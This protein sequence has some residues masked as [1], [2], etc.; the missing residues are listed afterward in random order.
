MSTIMSDIELLSPAGSVET[1]YA[2]INAGAD[3]VY[4]GGQ[5]FGARA[6]AENPD[7]SQ[8]L[9]AIDY[10][11]LN[12]KKI[13]LTVNTLLKDKEIEEQLYNYILPLYKQG[14]DAVI[15]QDIGVFCYIKNNFPD[16]D[17]HISTQMGVSGVSAAKLLK[18][19]G[20]SRIVTARELSLKELKKIHDNV[21]IEIESFI[22]GAMCYSYSGMCLFSSVAGGRSGNRGRC[23]GPC[24]QPYELYENGRHINNKNS[25]YALS[26]KDMNTLSILPEIINSGVYSLK[27]EGR[28]K[29]PEYVAGVVSVYRKYIDLYFDK[30]LENY[31]ISEED[32]DNLLGMYSRS[33]SCTG[34]YKNHNSK[35]MI[36]YEKPS[37]KTENDTFINDIREKYCKEKKQKEAVASITIRQNKPAILE[38][39]DNDISVSVMGDKAEI[40]SN[41]PLSEENVYKQLNKTNTS[42][43]KFH[44][45]FTYIDDNIFMPVKQLNELRRR[46]ITEFT[47]MYLSKYRRSVTVN[48]KCFEDLY[49]KNSCN[50]KSCNENLCNENNSHRI[51]LICMVSTS[52]QAKCVSEYEHIKEVY[53]STDYMNVIECAS[54]ISNILNTDRKCYVVMPAIFREKGIKYMENLLRILSDNMITKDEIGFVIR[55]IDELGY[56]L[57]NNITDYIIDNSLYAFNK[58]SYD[59]FKKHNAKRVT[60]SYELN[61][62]ELIR[63][64]YGDSEL[65]IYGKIPL[66]ISSGCVNMNYNSCDK[67]QKKINLKDRLGYNFTAYNCCEFCYNIIYNN[68]PLSLL[69]VHNKLHKIK[70]DN[71][72]I[73]FTLEDAKTT[74]IILDKFVKTF[75]YSDDINNISTDNS[76]TNNH[77]A[78]N[79]NIEDFE[80]TRGHFN[81][82]VE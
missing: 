64:N 79:D 2:G 23:A 68:I 13:Y 63:Q 46:A 69:G 59:F 51:N 78:N 31:K 53:V 18:E 26:L 3:A 61:Y 10:I 39:S 49:D 81:R 19:M 35:S 72:R 8:L 7:N 74:R 9:S 24:R 77:N 15:V 27:I 1:L 40:A 66:M 62:K 21:D 34:Y 5:L 4:I 80:F 29:S 17:I 47:E 82:G 16:M 38:I 22:H 45:I 36:S 58:Y 44:K 11:H 73:N 6:Y 54:V 12:N 33:G 55:N 65:I 52:A 57:Y 42:L 48:E 50:K 43:L 70:T 20:A 67:V 28:M 32:M 56:V 41:R 71:Y 75:Y 60:L 14:L 30:G 37:Y 76:N 25:M